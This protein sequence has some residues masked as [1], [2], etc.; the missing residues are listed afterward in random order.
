VGVVLNINCDY[1]FVDAEVEA[2]LESFVKDHNGKHLAVQAEEAKDIE[3][4]IAKWEKI[5][6][7]VSNHSFILCLYSNLG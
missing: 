4:V 2:K 7:E 1:F 5:F 3:E 6:K